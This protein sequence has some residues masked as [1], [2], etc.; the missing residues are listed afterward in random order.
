MDMKFKIKKAS[1]LLSMWVGGTEKNIAIMFEEAM[2]SNLFLILDEADSFFQNRGSAQRSWEVTQVNEMLVQMEKHKLPFVCTTNI[3]ESIDPA[4]FRRFTFKIGYDYLKRNQSYAIYE[5]YFG[6]KAPDK[7]LD[8]L[9]QLAPGDFANIYE[10]T[11]F[12][13][14]LNDDEIIEMLKEECEIKPSF[15]RK[16]GF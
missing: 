12:L 14:E 15:K 3:E 2:D 16:I 8:D 4:A 9:L 6:R 7:S 13:G 11:G 10:K 5:H 1:D